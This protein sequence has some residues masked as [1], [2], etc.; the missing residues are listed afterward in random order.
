MVLTHEVTLV[1]DVVLKQSV[2]V[3]TQEREAS[4][5]VESMQEAMS[6]TSFLLVLA[7]VGP[8]VKAIKDKK[9]KQ[10]RK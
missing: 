2:M 3:E 9:V 6:L 7:E 5:S 1:I 10:A 8:K 4:A